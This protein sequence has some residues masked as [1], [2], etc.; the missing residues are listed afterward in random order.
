[1]T[2]DSVSEAERAALA[3]AYPSLDVT[4][5]KRGEVV[6]SEQRDVSGRVVRVDRYQKFMVGGRNRQTVSLLVAGQD[7]KDVRIAAL[8]AEIAAL[9]KVQAEKQAERQAAKPATKTE[10]DPKKD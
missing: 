1:M 3:A 5:V 7:E 8:E 9:K 2:E 4:D 10:P 6:V